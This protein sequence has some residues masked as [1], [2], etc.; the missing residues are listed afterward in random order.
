MGEKMD[1]VVNFQNVYF[2]S[3]LKT[4]ALFIFL[5]SIRSH[6]LG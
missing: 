1:T 6:A 4:F 5:N 3:E 2:F